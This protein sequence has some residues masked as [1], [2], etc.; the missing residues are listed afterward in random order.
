MPIIRLSPEPIQVDIYAQAAACDDFP[1]QCTPEGP[2]EY[3]GR[4]ALADAKIEAYTRQRLELATESLS[5]GYYF[6]NSAVAS[7]S[8]VLTSTLQ[9]PVHIQHYLPPQ[10][11]LLPISTTL[12]VGDMLEARALVEEGSYSVTKIDY[13]LERE[14][15]LAGT[16]GLQIPAGQT[17][18]LGSATRAD[19]WRIRMPV[20]GS[21]LGAGWRIKAVAY[22]EQ[23][24]FTSVFSNDELQV[25][26]A[27]FPHAS[28]INLPEDG[29]LRGI[30]T[31]KASTR[32]AL[33]DGSELRLYLIDDF[34]KWVEL[35]HFEP[36][37]DAWTYRFDTAK[38]PNGT[39]TLLTTVHSVEPAYTTPTTRH[40]TFDNQLDGY[41]FTSPPDNAVVRGDVELTTSTE[42]TISQVSGVQFLLQDDQGNI[43]DLGQAEHID[44]NYNLVWNSQLVT[45]GVYTITA[46]LQGTDGRY[47]ELNKSI[48][49]INKS[50]S[51][52][53]ITSE[54]G[55]PQSGQ[56]PVCWQTTGAISR[57]LRLE[58]SPDNGLSWLELA[59]SLE[60][61]GC[62]SWDSRQV[63]DSTNA[64][65]RIV[66]SDGYAR[67]LALSNAFVLNNTLEPPVLS[68]LAPV[69]NTQYG[70]Y[71]RIAWESWS[72]DSK[73][74]T[75]DLAYRSAEGLWITLGTSMPGKGNFLWDITN[76][77]S[78]ST[79]IRIRAQAAPNSTTSVTRNIQIDPLEPLTIRLFSPKGGERLHDEALVLWNVPQA[80]EKRV[81]IDL[82]FSDN[83]GQTWLP[84][85]EGLEDT[86]YYQWQ[87]SFLPP[88]DQ[89][90]VKAVAYTTDSRAEAISAGTFAI[91]SL[92]AITCH[93]LEPLDGAVLYGY[94]RIDWLVTTNSY[95]KRTV[96]LGIRPV[97]Q[98]FWDPVI[99]QTPD[100][101]F[102]LWNT[103][104]YSD[105]VYELRLSVYAPG[106]ASP[107]EQIIRVI[108]NNHANHPPVIQLTSPPFATGSGSMLIRWKAADIDRQPLSAT[109]QFKG[110]ASAWQD[111]A[112][113]AGTTGVLSLA[114]KPD[115]YRA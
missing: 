101:G 22:D 10:V 87:L 64:R 26:N 78:F 66:E 45:D 53:F 49:V 3:L 48:Q 63:P 96:S 113:I 35:G 59:S 114:A 16:E 20:S 105:G 89:Y 47:T 17:K 43:E 1:V 46:F 44:R 106:S 107:L 31:L 76:L 100:D 111:I 74:V 102:Y 70:Q 55:Q 2:T 32:L 7:E 30:I 42:L 104:P 112:G 41:A 18:W 95:D 98:T 109:L 12:A 51:V 71:V 94:Q 80:S 21:W 15:N 57:T 60:A 77:P 37:N 24:V 79:Q 93:I 88:G 97:G 108:L 8:G 27:G 99:Q 86:S 6:I 13:Y 39:Y 4:F 85:V 62:Y 69:E 25:V 29:V 28:F 65:L 84:L 9:T 72:P 38:F 40:V 75:V 5:D 91:G 68:V 81:S 103:T 92:P 83:A 33:S 23:N 19:N 90:R 54:Y 56:L 50:P 11:T 82:Y 115:Y 36:G 52:R 73:P 110:P 34:A 61:S 14:A 58:F 67:I